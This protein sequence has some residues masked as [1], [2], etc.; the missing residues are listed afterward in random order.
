[1]AIKGLSIPTFGKYVNTSGTISYTDG[2]VCGHAISY[3]FDPSIADDNPLYGDNMI[4]ENDSG[5]F[6]NGTLTLNTS[7]L[8]DEVA[9]MLLGL[10]ETEVSVGTGQTATTVKQYA[11]DTDAAAI[12]VGIGFIEEHQVNDV[13]YYKAR[14]LPR[15]KK[16][17][18]SMT[19]TTRGE[20]ID[21]QT[22]E[23]TF[24]VSRAEDA[25]KTWLVETELLETEAEAQ[26]FL[27]QYL[28]VAA[29]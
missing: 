13:T 25:K 20:T 10:T 28:G 12:D 15:C 22:P 11:Y 3:N 19:A 9:K 21:W 8:P 5:F 27:N 7:E 17:F 24:A 18:D 2:V 14:V 1:M 23:I 16:N 29:G 6:Q 4:V 26:A